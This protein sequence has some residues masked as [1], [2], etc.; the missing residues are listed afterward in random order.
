MASTNTLNYDHNDTIDNK[1]AIII[2]TITLFFHETMELHD[3]V[4][5]DIGKTEE[6]SARWLFAVADMA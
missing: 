3:H 4:K 1:H 2:I 6:L 5:D